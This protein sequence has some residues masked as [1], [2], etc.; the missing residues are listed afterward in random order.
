MINRKK[1]TDDIVT[2]AAIGAGM[3]RALEWV[4]VVTDGQGLGA[5]TDEE[6]VMLRR[7]LAGLAPTRRELWIEGQLEVGQ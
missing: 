7:R 3:R 4:H 5:L 1:M 6:L 2:L